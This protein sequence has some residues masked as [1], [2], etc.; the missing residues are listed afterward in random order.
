MLIFSRV[1]TERNHPPVVVFLIM[2][3]SPASS[4]FEKQAKK[5]LASLHSP[6]P[7]S[8]LMFNFSEE[9]VLAVIFLKTS[10]RIL[11]YEWMAHFS[12]LTETGRRQHATPSDHHTFSHE[13]PTH[14]LSGLHINAQNR[15]RQAH[16]HTHA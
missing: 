7:P 1:K 12:Q 11:F 3:G 5:I 10:N 15:M 2:N 14:L 9:Y 13:I 16:T 6:S 4:N 8:L